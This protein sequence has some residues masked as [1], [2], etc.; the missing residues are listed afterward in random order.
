[1]GVIAQYSDDDLVLVHPQQGL[2]DRKA[3]GLGD[4]RQVRQGLRGYL[5]QGFPGDD[6]RRARLASD[7]LGC[8]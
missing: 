3:R 6:G 4:H 2:Q 8:A 7:G 1:V 5:S